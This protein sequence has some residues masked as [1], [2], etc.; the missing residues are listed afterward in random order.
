MPRWLW[1][2]PLAALTGLGAV[3]VFRLG[4]IVATLEQ[5]DVIARYAA[6]YLQEAGTGA[7]PTD[8]AAYPAPDWANVW[9]VV[10]CKPM[11]ETGVFEAVYYVNRFGGRVAAPLPAAGTSPFP[12]LEPDT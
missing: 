8:C 6:L 3:L 5:S 4:W 10:R 9:I 12:E 7:K 2:A 1:W 11:G